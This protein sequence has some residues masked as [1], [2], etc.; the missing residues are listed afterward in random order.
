LNLLGGTEENRKIYHDSRYQER[1][2]NPVAIE[3]EAAGIIYVFVSNATNV[4]SAVARCSESIVNMDG[5]MLRENGR[6][7][8]RTC[9]IHGWR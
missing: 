4:L 8:A 6:P 7:K 1:Y 5:I 9:S 2:S 3:Y